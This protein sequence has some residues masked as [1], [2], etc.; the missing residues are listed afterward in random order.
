MVLYPPIEIGPQQRSDKLDVLF[1]V[2][3]S[4]SMA[5]KQHILSQSVSSFLTRLVNPFCVDAQGKPTPTQPA[6]GD[7]PCV[8]GSRELTPVKDI[9]LG[10]I[11]SSIGSHGGGV[12]STGSADDHVDDHAEL[13]PA[14]RAN[15]PSW[16]NAGYLSYDAAG[17]VGV[18]DVNSVI[19]DLT[20]II[21]AATEHGCGYEAPLEAMYRFL[22]DPEPPVS[23]SQVNNQSV[24]G[25]INQALLT[26]RKRF[27]RPDSAVAIVILSDES[28]CSI[29]DDGIGWFVGSE[30]RMPRSTVAC[31][32]DANDPCCRSCAQKEGSPPAGCAALSADANCKQVAS[33]QLYATWD[34]AHDSLNLRCFDQKRRFGFDLLYPVERYSDA[35]SNPQVRNRNQVL[36]PN[37]LLAGDEKGPRSATLISVSVIVGAPWQ[38]LATT[39]S[40]SSGHPIE[41]MDGAALD[42]NGRWPLLIGDRAHNVRPSDP[43]MIESIEERTGQNSLTN[44]AIVS[45]SSTNPLANA[46]NGHEHKVPSLDDLQFACIF[47]L[48]TPKACPSGDS[49]CDCAADKNGKT[50][51]IQASNSPLCQPPEGGAV[52]TTQYFGKGYPGTRELIFA[53]QLGARS[54]P[55][56]VCPRTLTDTTSPDY[57]YTP[58]FSALITR[59]GATLK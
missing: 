20:T 40:L 35:L 17:S 27:L 5:D 22:V 7:A 31:A 39:A 16:D 11:T 41:Y 53:Q 59:I 46:I 38:D 50:D 58:A 3:N 6:S 49:L 1:V 43:F 26:Q 47:P 37:P 44:M 54:V 19:K 24:P 33:G 48:P 56:S 18:S 55:A 32:T 42:S 13:L 4:V 29:R 12:C 36:V 28:D 9:H 52:T 23:V 14:Q 45:S 34:V 10:V 8:T 15:L 57:A 25:A 2:D 30:S 51:A 21:D